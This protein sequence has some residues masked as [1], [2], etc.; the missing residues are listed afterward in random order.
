MG[1]FLHEWVDSLIQAWALRT[2]KNSKNQASG[3]R[4]QLST[5]F[6]LKCVSPLGLASKS[7]LF[8]GRDANRR[9]EY[10]QGWRLVRITSGELLTS[11]SPGL[12]ICKKTETL[13]T[14]LWGF[15]S[16]PRWEGVFCWL[17][18]S[19]RW[20]SPHS[21]D[22]YPP[23]TTCWLGG[24]EVP[25]LRNF[26]QSDKKRDVKAAAVDEAWNAHLGHPFGWRLDYVVYDLVNL[27]VCHLWFLRL[28]AVDIHFTRYF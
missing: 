18:G 23:Q 10:K 4:K 9:E 25:R 22:F 24:R 21:F 12:P 6:F 2:V 1:L 8:D 20:V 26:S 13:V 5:C 7:W 17:I 28:I 11:S 19:W 3:L 27:L 15:I 16:S 14:L